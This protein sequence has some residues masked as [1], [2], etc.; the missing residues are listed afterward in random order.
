MQCLSRFGDISGYKINEAK[1]EAMMINGS[2][3][4]QLNDKKFKWSKLG[5]RYLGVILTDNS[6]MLYKQNYDKLLTQVK[7]DLQRWKILPLSL[8]G[9]IETIRM[10][11]L[12]QFLFLFGA[13]PVPVPNSTFKCIEKLIS[14][15]IWQNKRPRVRLKILNSPKGNRG[16]ALPH[17]KSYYWAAQLK[18]LVTW[19]RMDTDTRWFQL[20]QSSVLDRPIS[21]LIFMDT[22]QWKKLKIQNEGIKFTLSVWEKARKRLK[23]PLSLSRASK[24]TTITDFLPARMDNAYDR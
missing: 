9:R 11:V 2:W 21:A 15:F 13:L 24:I 3:P 8:T 14:E 7:N 6:S 22:K 23:L 19:I 18:A 4:N 12:P 20:E 17:L 1:S 5:F 16:L 10:N